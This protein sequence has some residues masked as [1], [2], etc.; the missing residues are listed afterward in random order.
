MLR[1]M[2]NG[3]SWPPY[4]SYRY[5]GICVWKWRW[6][7]I[8]TTYAYLHDIHVDDNGDG[9]HYMHM[10]DDERGGIKDITPS[11]KTCRLITKP[12]NNNGGN[13]I[14][15]RV[16]ILHFTPC[17]KC[18][19]INSNSRSIYYCTTLI[20]IHFSLFIT[21]IV[22]SCERTICLQCKYKWMWFIIDARA[23]GG[24]WWHYVKRTDEWVMMDG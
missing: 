23:M 10:D 4:D 17:N 21:K 11:T 3:W 15:L 7:H 5:I 24:W 2:S 18:D 12:T 14:H 8:D 1:C 19:G 20:T 6:S 22:F 13:D 9:W 16:V